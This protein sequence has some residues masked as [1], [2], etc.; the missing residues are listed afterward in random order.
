MVEGQSEDL[1]SGLDS[2]SRHGPDP[3]SDEETK[4]RE[5]NS[6]MLTHLP[7]RSGSGDRPRFFYEFHCL[8]VLCRVVHTFVT[9]SNARKKDTHNY[10]DNVKGQRKIKL[11]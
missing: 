7:E 5:P 4:P 2:C 8:R 11:S 6:R 3:R 1:D 9:F 10:T